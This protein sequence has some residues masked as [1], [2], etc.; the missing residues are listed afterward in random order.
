MDQSLIRRLRVK[1]VAINMALA[2]L[3]LL[4]TF[5]GVCVVNHAHAVSEITEH[6][7]Y[8]LTRTSSMMQS[9]SAQVQDVQPLEKPE[10][11]RSIQEL[12]LSGAIS[13]VMQSAASNGPASSVDDG[14]SADAQG[15]AS[16]QDA[17]EP[18]A[19][20]SDAVATAE[21]IP[22]A[23]VE[24]TGANGAA[25]GGVAGSMAP[26][27]IGSTENTSAALTAVFKGERNGIYTTIPAYTTAM[28]PESILL[29]ADAAVIESPD[30]EGYLPEFDLMYQKLAT[31]GG[32]YVAYADASSTH[33]WQTLA[34]L[35]TLIGL[36]ALVGF[37]L[38][39]IGFSSWALRPVAVSLRQ[40]QQFT[41]DASHELKT[42]LTVILAN[43]S[44]LRSHPDSTVAE[45]MQWV[46]SS[47]RE[48]DRMQLLVNDM[49]SL[50]RPKASG[51]QAAVQQAEP[52]DFSD[53][54]EGEVLQFESVAF[55]RG[56][57]LDSSIQKGVMV[58]GD[59]EKLGRMASTLIDNACKYV[60]D[61]GLVD[62]RLDVIA[63][64]ALGDSVA[65]LRV[66]NTGEAI[67][68]D[69]LEHL[70][71]RFYRADKAR[72]GGKG[73]YGLGLAI[74]R[75]I[76]RE[77]NGDITV[78]SSKSAGTTFTVTLPLSEA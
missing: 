47:E 25:A 66:H 20:A 34:I 46:E 16:L 53:L 78:E 1:F 59:P 61:N 55:E 49:L 18:D 48:A 56:I 70:F 67:P 28:L 6:L 5:G 33:E 74:G 9:K 24:S 77:A 37:F 10:E 13:S 68:P 63:K 30:S 58:M 72:T 39:N 45:Q 65:R 8:V 54:V 21:V 32:W 3:V 76:A 69:Q 40:Q 17:D 75:Q 14:N 43:L 38:I 11:E 35:L 2:F 19:F 57:L 64:G 22:Q 73:G 31:T 4:L 36:I 26:I 60:E 52:V 44:I 51:K 7:T 23:S 12:Q 71:D 27:V 42:P 62:V 29:R 41:A 15:E 50:A